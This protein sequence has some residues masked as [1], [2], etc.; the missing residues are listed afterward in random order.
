M[1]S[2]N[3]AITLADYRGI[4]ALVAMKF[5][6]DLVDADDTRVKAAC[7]WLSLLL[8]ARV[9]K[10]EISVSASFTDSYS[11]SSVY[12]TVRDKARV[13][14]LASSLS[15]MKRP[16]SWQIPGPTPTLFVSGKRTINT[17]AAAFTQLSD[18][19][20]AA[21]T[22]KGGQA[23]AGLLGGYRFTTRKRSRR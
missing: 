10:V 7:A 22:N 9:I 6:T 23:Y 3:V 21:V 15:G 14:G 17:S 19:I 11:L 12:G 2:V 4:K 20:A 13:K 5:P 8:S 1:A 16:G 18:A